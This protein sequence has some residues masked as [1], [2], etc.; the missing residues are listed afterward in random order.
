M[1]P[2]ITVQMSLVLGVAAGVAL[3]LLLGV[4]TVALAGMRARLREL[5]G[6]SADGLIGQARSRVPQPLAGSDFETLVQALD[7][8]DDDKARG[9]F[10]RLVRRLGGLRL[11]GWLL[12]AVGIPPLAALPLLPAILAHV[13][14][15]A[16][17]RLPVDLAAAG[18]LTSL[19]ATGA[20]LPLAA[21]ALTLAFHLHRFE[22]GRRASA[23]AGLLQHAGKELR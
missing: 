21:T 22:E 11:S 14:W 4:M 17:G 2:F 6:L 8:R 15:L 18:T 5:H 9:A 13:S 19:A 23:A 10:A 20:L 3:L 16:G 1:D 7:R 12:L